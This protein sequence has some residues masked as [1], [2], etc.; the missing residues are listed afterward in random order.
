MALQSALGL[1]RPFEVNR[2]TRIPDQACVPCHLPEVRD[3]HPETNADVSPFTEVLAGVEA[4]LLHVSP[5]YY[6]FGVPRGDGSAVVVIPAFLGFDLYL[7][8]LFEW[9]RR[10]GYS[11][12]F[13]GES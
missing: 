9:L 11:P 6:G 7:V 2:R 12:F 8:E 5:V 1:I 13:S 4:L 3:F 10:V